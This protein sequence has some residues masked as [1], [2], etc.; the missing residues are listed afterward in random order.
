MKAH[1]YFVG[2]LVNSSHCTYLQQCPAP[3]SSLFSG[4]FVGPLA[5]VRRN[6]YLPA[7]LSLHMSH[8]PNPLQPGLRLKQTLRGIERKYFSSPKQETLLTFDIL[9]IDIQT[10]IIPTCDDGTVRWV[11][12]T[13]GHFL[14]LRAGE[15][16]VPSRD[17]FDPSIHLTCCDAGL[18]SSASCTEYLSFRL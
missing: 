13:A 1:P 9:P 14:M 16:T 7:V 2:G 17:L 18:H 11:A 6:H 10:I 3:I 15:F 12:I 8:G 5:S 4:I